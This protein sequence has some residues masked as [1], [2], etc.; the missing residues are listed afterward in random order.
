MNHPEIVSRDDWR[1]E[2]RAILAE[3][4]QATRALDALA[5][6]RRRLPMTKID[7]N[8]RFATPSGMRSFAEAFDG[9]PQLIVYHNMLAPGSDHICLGCSSFCDGIGN[10]AH[11]HARRTSFIVVSRAT[12][13]RI[14]QVKARMGW[15]FPWYS[16]NGTS[17]Y[18]DFVEAPASFGLSVFLMQDGAIYQTYFTTGRGVELPCNTRG[19]LDITPYGR[20][21]SWEDSPPG[22]PQEQ[23]HSWVRL[24][25][26]YGA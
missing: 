22:W 13:P 11:L 23:T 24:H 7:R 4:K 8:Y 21:E 18:E 6:R 19:L 9:R 15:N 20:Q 1:H 12:L 2:R 16:S 5:A 17:F 14:E 10:L 3:E 26:E 25:D